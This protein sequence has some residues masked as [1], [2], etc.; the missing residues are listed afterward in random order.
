MMKTK[1]ATNGLQKHE[2]GVFWRRFLLIFSVL[3]LPTLLL[4]F[5]YTLQDARAVYD[6]VIRLHILAHSDEAEEQALKLKVR[7]AILDEMKDTLQ[8]LSGRESAEKTLRESLDR[9]E[10]IAE[11]KVA[12]EGYKHSVRVLLCEEYYP[13]REY[14][15]MR[16]PAGEYLSL[17]VLIGEG[18]GQ[19]W[20]CMVYPPLCT[21]S[22][23]AEDGLVEAGFSSDQVRLLTEDED[24]KYVIRF[25]LAEVVS[26]AVKKVKGWFS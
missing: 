18:A 19:N 11:E 23:E 8:G 1:K 22:A 16:L 21:S 20:W 4:S 15:G 5:L 24:P 13:T 14:E 17:R 12:E 6:G 25:K 2:K 10:A 3:L 26:K 7:D 9:V